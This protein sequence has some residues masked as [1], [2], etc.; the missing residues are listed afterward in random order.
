MNPTQIV[1]AVLFASEAPLNAEEIAR[2]DEA[3]DEDLIEEAVQELNAAYSESEAPSPA[4]TDVDV[5][6][7]AD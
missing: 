6:S 4:A 7:G 2:A 5:A 3:L 1:E